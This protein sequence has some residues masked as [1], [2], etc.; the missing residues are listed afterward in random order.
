MTIT[1]AAIKPISDFDTLVLATQQTNI[2]LMPSGVGPVVQIT[3]RKVDPVAADV[4]PNV[5]AVDAS[6]SAVQNNAGVTIAIV[7]AGVGALL[8]LTPAG[9]K[10]MKGI[11]GKKKRGKASGGGVL[12]L[13][14][15]GGAAAYWYFNKDNSD[16][17][18]PGATASP[19]TN[20]NGAIPV[21]A[22]PAPIIAPVEVATVARG[23]TAGNDAIALQRDW[24]AIAA[25]VAKMT[26]SE[27]I[28]LYNYFYGYV[29][30]EKVLHQLPPTTGS[31][32]DGGWDTQ[33]YNAI[34]A[35]RSKYS[36]NI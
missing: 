24:P 31:W 23:Y 29:L 26:D 8:L 10:A 6:G 22:Q 15:V 7:A 28:S 4:V 14:L 32:A 13:L 33:L 25:A 35:I 27:I 16:A 17:Q 30:P 11:A 9:K 1:S 20:T 3:P 19:V 12:P 2:A 18:T 36:L 5:A 34:A 21:T